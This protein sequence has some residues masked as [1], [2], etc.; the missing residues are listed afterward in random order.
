MTP[1]APWM[2]PDRHFHRY[3]SFILLLFVT[4]FSTIST[5]AQ[6]ANGANKFLGCQVTRRQYRTDFTQYWNQV[7]G[8]NECRW[9]AIESSRDQMNWSAAEDFAAFA[10]E[11]R[12]PWTFNSLLADGAYASW[13]PNIGPTLLFEEI[14]EWMDSASARYPDPAVIYVVTDDSHHFPSIITDALGG[15]GSTGYDWLIN[16]FTMARQRWPHAIL[17]LNELDN[18]ESENVLQQTLNV[19]SSLKKAKAP[20]DAIGCQA[21]N[22]WRHATDSIKANI[23][24]LA[25]A[26]YPILITE[27]DIPSNDDDLQD[28]I[29]QEQFTMFWN[30]PKVIGVTYWGYVL[31][32]TWQNNAG[33]MTPEG[34]ERPAL[35]WLKNYVKNNLNP[36]NDFPAMLNPGTTVIHPCKGIPSLEPIPGLQSVN[37]T[38]CR[39]FDLQGRSAGWYPTGITG[40]PST[41]K[42]SGWYTMQ[43]DD[44]TG[45]SVRIFGDR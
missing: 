43:R 3:R 34:I 16:A 40:V 41:L 44:H 31:G 24:R 15:S 10:R 17:I 1:P 33:L 11:N 27:F 32:S 38:G 8:E 25:A 13:L 42:A 2:Y 20:I 18:I 4:L 14:G 21:H 45:F 23:D 37:H 36:P 35:T 29:M 26:G 12:I 28:S 30:H 7:I 22:T 39:L 19:L 6:P 9:A 5:Q